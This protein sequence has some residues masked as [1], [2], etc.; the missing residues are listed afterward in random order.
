MKAP[1]AVM[2]I[3]SQLAVAAERT[4]PRTFT[5][6]ETPA[7]LL[8]LFTSEGC[9]SCPPAEA[10]MTSLKTDPALWRTLVP[11]VFHVDYWD[12]LGWPDRFA[13]RDFTQR[14]RRYAA[15]SRASVYTPGF[16]AA[17]REWKGWFRREP[18]PSAPPEKIGRLTVALDTTRRATVTFAPT[19]TPATAL[20]AWVAL[21][22]S[23]LTSDVK[24]G[25]NRGRTLRHD[26][27]VLHLRTRPLTRVG[28]RWTAILDLPPPDRDPP[29]ALA[30]W[31]AAA[32]GQPPLQATGGWLR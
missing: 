14:Q 16:F 12:G 8:E 26:F 20:H 28:E 19:S 29:T 7:V 24:R 11:V 10:W 9:S 4:E 15:A 5:S 2:L 25:E 31:V 22:G 17:G 18:A 32:E 3:G 13:S 30:A 23:D 27:V 21:L 6:A 1:L